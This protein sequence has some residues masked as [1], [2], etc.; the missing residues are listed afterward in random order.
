MKL[1]LSLARVLGLGLLCA[2]TLVP[3]LRAQTAVS[4]LGQTVGATGTIGRYA[5]GGEE[6]RRVFTFTTGAS[7]GGYDFTGITMSFNGASGSPG[8]L[9]VSLYSTFDPN[10]SAGGGTLLTALSLSLGSPFT[11]PTA[12]FSGSAALAASTTYYL[13]FSSAFA[14]AGNYYSYPV[15]NTGLENPGGLAGWSIGDIGYESNYNQNWT[16][17]SGPALFSV[18]ATAAIP[19]PST[20]VLLFG[21]AAFGC[22]MWRRKSAAT[23]T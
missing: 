7:A 5:G 19:E 13:Q 15:A 1:P 12:S 20:Y 11:G 22:V 14:P 21:V 17:Q 8:D 6:W 16:A 4:N 3:S 2:L 23:S 10:T 9:S 18:D